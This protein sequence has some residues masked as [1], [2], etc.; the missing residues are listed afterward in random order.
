MVPCGLTVQSYK[1]EEAESSAGKGIG[2]VSKERVRDS[3]QEIR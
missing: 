2:I 1:I 3:K